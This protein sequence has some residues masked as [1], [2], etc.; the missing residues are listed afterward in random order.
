MLSL[1]LC[2]ANAEIRRC[3]DGDTQHTRRFDTAVFNSSPAA[4][5]PTLGGA[6]SETVVATTTREGDVRASIPSSVFVYNQPPQQQQQ[7]PQQ[8]RTQ[9]QPK[10]SEARRGR[11]LLTTSFVTG[12]LQTP[13]VSQ[14]AQATAQLQSAATVASNHSPVMA[15]S[16]Q[17]SNFVAY[18][19]AQ[20]S[21]TFN[22]GHQGTTPSSQPNFTV[23]NTTPP[24]SPPLTYPSTQ[25]LRVP[26]RQSSNTPSPASSPPPNLL[27]PHTF[28]QAVS[29]PS[30]TTGS[31]RQ[32]LST[33]FPSLLPGSSPEAPAYFRAVTGAPTNSR[34]ESSD[35]EG[36]NN[37]IRELD[38][39]TYCFTDLT[40]NERCDPLDKP[41]MATMTRSRVGV[42]ITENRKPLS[43]NTLSP[44]HQPYSEEEDTDPAILAL[45]ESN[46]EGTELPKS[47]ASALAKSPMEQFLHSI[48][49]NPNAVSH[50]VAEVSSLLEA[51]LTP[52]SGSTFTPFPVTKSITHGS[53]A[54]KP[55]SSQLRRTFNPL[56]FSDPEIHSPS[57][58]L[59]EYLSLTP[60]VSAA[61]PFAPSQGRPSL[62]TSMDSLFSYPIGFTQGANT[63]C[64]SIEQNQVRQLPHHSPLEL[65]QLPSMQS[66]VQPQILT[67]VLNHQLH[68]DSDQE[69]HSMTLQQ[70]QLHYTLPQHVYLHQ[71]GSRSNTQPRKQETAPL[72]MHP[73]PQVG[74]AHQQFSSHVQSPH[75][76]PEVHAH[77]PPSP[78]LC[79][80]I[81]SQPPGLSSQASAQLPNQVPVP[82]RAQRPSQHSVQTEHPPSITEQ[83]PQLRSVNTP[84]PVALPTSAPV[85]IMTPAPISTERHT[86][87]QEASQTELH[88]PSQ[89]SQNVT[90]ENNSQVQSQQVPPQR[91]RLS[92]EKESSSVSPRVYRITAS[93]RLTQSAPLPTNLPQSKTHPINICTTYRENIDRTNQQG[94]SPD[95][96]Y[97]RYA[98]M[99]DMKDFMIHVDVKEITDPRTTLMIKNIPNK[100][101]QKMLLEEIDAHHTGV[102]DFFYLP[103]DF[104]NKCNVGY[105]FINMVSTVK[106]A[107]FYTE[108]NNKRWTRFNSEK[109]CN[110]TYAR[111]QGIVQLIDHFK[112]SSLL[113]EEEKVRPVMLLN[114]TLQPFPVGVSL[115]VLHLEKE[116]RDIIV[117]SDKLPYVE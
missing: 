19:T 93:G 55:P 112:T 34:R 82:C 110:I 20:L 13:A 5:G 104:K 71:Q 96:R 102:Y 86:P 69:V 111:I 116:H 66:R 46:S 105:A 81:L 67:P 27:S 51:N 60:Q 91:T 36:S 58:E 72:Q 61:I 43:S 64:S 83:E 15:V 29:P 114:N 75:R 18:N 42:G 24:V 109:I 31:R 17:P 10:Q 26:M 53:P 8:Q 56:S 40:S 94:H 79:P 21:P 74:Q 101:S 11:S 7:Q 78:Q 90:E 50:N 73:Y 4:C 44:C 77:T 70:S 35:W 103:I 106:I 68:A 87:P 113:A 84:T 47:S 57:Q 6:I 3:A 30:N 76:S 54:L 12:S 88:S 41:T 107:P 100:Y 25:P 99:P 14:Q 85:Q 37:E 1:S 95:H 38:T 92:L 63:P 117:T 23:Y 89:P 62:C 22:Y 97:K 39:N 115:H 59:P 49:P 2:N 32:Y 108:F 16:C 52:P 9:V 33:S 28:L 98:M 48:E 80:V 65:P 45:I